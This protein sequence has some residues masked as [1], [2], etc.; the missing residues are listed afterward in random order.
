MTE[1]IEHASRAEVAPSTGAVSVRNRATL[2]GT[3][4]AIGLSLQRPL[5]THA[6]LPERHVLPSRS[7]VGTMMCGDPDSLGLSLSV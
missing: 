3:L 1:T 2:P 6:V 5:L 7:A 4:A